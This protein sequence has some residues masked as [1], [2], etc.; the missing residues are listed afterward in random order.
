MERRPASVRWPMG[1]SPPPD[2]PSP[3]TSLKGRL[4]WSEADS[5]LLRGGFLDWWRFSYLSSGFNLNAVSGRLSALRL[6]VVVALMG[7]TKPLLLLS[8][9]GVEVEAASGALWGRG[10]VVLLKELLHSL[11][12]STTL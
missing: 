2:P 8:A 11:A 4:C 7:R 6:Y 10:P 9:L 3:T 1:F 5:Q 12:V